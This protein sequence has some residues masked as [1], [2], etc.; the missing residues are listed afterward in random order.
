[1]FNG[2]LVDVLVCTLRGVYCIVYVGYC[3]QCVEFGSPER[4]A[5]IKVY[6][7]E[8]V[9]RTRTFEDIKFT[10]AISLV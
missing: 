10:P 6:T 3:P 1:M 8:A 9:H 5:W 7:R 2:F 4:Q